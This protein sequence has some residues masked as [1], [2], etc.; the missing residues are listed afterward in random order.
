M[1]HLCF[2]KVFAN[3]KQIQSM[4]TEE[5]EPLENLVDDVN[6]EQVENTSQSR[7]TEFKEEVSQTEDDE[8]SLVKKEAQEYKDKF[9]RL[10]AEFDNFKKRNAKERVELFK[11][12]GQEVI[13]ELLPIL[14]DFHR[15][16]KVFESDTN[17]ENYANGVKLI[18]DKLYKTLQNKGLKKIESIGQD[19]NIE[20][21]E[22][23]AE[24]PAPT[25]DLKGKVL[26]E[27]QSG[28]TLNDVI[29]RYAKVVVGK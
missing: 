22:A 6:N 1:S 4:T 11:T 17:A 14:D 12:A 23:I 10:F 2:G 27:T 29:I 13:R 26:D 8:L 25:D 7:Q 20:Q 15:A 5:K 21:H 9:I 16:D 3:F 18:H 24:I 28:F 19:F